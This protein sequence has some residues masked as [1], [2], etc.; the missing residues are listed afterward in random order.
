[1]A[2]SRYAIDGPAFT[3]RTEQHV[4]GRRRGR[5]QDR[6]VELPQWTV[7]LEEIDAAVLYAYGV[8]AA[9]LGESRHN[10]GC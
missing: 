7:E 6:D 3:E 5:V 10:T 9:I 1:M 4:E 8:D 2:A